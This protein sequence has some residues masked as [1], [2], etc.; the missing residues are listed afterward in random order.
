MRV[1]MDETLLDD[2]SDVAISLDVKNKIKSLL[3]SLL[4]LTF[5]K[6]MNKLISENRFNCACRRLAS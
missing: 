1:R 6:K 5:V 4:S 3:S 2:D